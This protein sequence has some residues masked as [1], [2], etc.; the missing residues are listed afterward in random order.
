MI[1]VSAVLDFESK[2]ARDKVIEITADILAQYSGLIRVIR[3]AKDLASPDDAE[4]WEL[5]LNKTESALE[6][7]QGMAKASEGAVR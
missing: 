1:I 6:V 3:A 5:I 2:S 4:G 7:G